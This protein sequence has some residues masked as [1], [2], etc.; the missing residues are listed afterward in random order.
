MEE[1]RKNVEIAVE[2]PKGEP[3]SRELLEMRLK[4]L[5]PEEKQTGDV[6]KMALDFIN[7]LVEMNELMIEKI[8]ENPRMAQVFADVVSGKR[9]A[10]TALVRYF[11]KGVMTAEEG[12]PEYDE[13][14]A[15][16]AEFVKERE[17]Y[18][19]MQE[20]YDAKAI[21]WFNAFRGYCD[22]MG[23]DGQEYEQ[24]IEDLLVAPILE[25]EA[26]DEVFDR[27]INAVNYTKD[28]EDA[29]AAGEIK[30]RNTNINEMKA[31]V[32]DGIPKGLTSHAAPVEQPKRKV[33][34]LIAKA[35]NA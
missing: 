19:Q 20:E 23:L 17:H 5:L 24:K 10:D 21:T 18:K 12:T 16:D 2:E 4:E 25:W 32:G 13:L 29:F 22:R 35:L 34:S 33:N 1:E 15:A 26:T 30:G 31:K 11:G 27:L 9:K 6:E 7:E 14:M 3:T 8:T 28:T